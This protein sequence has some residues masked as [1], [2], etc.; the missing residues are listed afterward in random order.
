MAVSTQV[1]LPEVWPVS[2]SLISDVQH[3]S[4]HGR[5]GTQGLALL[6]SH[7]QQGE[8]EAHSQVCVW[9]LM[10]MCCGMHVYESL[11]YLCM[12]CIGKEC[13]VCG[14]YAYIVSVDVWCDCSM[15]CVCEIWHIYDHYT[16]I[17]LLETPHDRGLEPCRELPCSG[18]RFSCPQEAL[19]LILAAGLSGS[20]GW[21]L[22]HCFQLLIQYV[23][24][25]VCIY[26][27]VCVHV[28]ACAYMYVISN[29]LHCTVS[30]S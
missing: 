8:T 11:W 5:V 9:C 17:R 19:G 18:R 29:Q 16:T 6:S 20:A 2:S 15:V 30:L 21:C 12:V 7:G 27:Y 28:H 26:V 22:Q 23:C 1:L 3:N 25:H 24:I 10:Y 13:H 14:V 4:G